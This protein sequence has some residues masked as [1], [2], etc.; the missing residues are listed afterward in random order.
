MGVIVDSL[1]YDDEAP[2]PAQPDGTGP[3]L[4][5]RNPA[6]D[7]TLSESWAAS[8]ENGTPGAKNDMFSGIDENAGSETPLEFSLGQNY[9]NPFNPMT[10]IPFEIPEIGRVKIEV[11]SITGQSVGVILDDNLAPGLY[12]AL[13][14]SQNLS[15]GMYLYRIKANGFTQTRK[16]LLVK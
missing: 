5:L 2:W 8:T 16:M 12:Y 7:N 15:N 13:F 11:F 10:T 4:A 1:T 14:T 9:P 6:D 3:S